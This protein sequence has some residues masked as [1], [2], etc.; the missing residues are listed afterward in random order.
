MSKIGLVIER[1]Y[2]TRVFKKSFLLVTILVPLLLMGFYAI[3]L[4]I[5]FKDKKAEQK[6]AVIDKSGFFKD[7]VKTGKNNDLEFEIL[8]NNNLEQAVKEYKVLGYNGLLYIPDGD[9]VAVKNYKLYLPSNLSFSTTMAIED[10]INKQVNDNRLIAQG[11]D[12]DTYNQSAPKVDLET[13]IDSGK[14]QNSQAS[15]GVAFAVSMVCGLL[16]YLMMIIYGTMVMRGVS[17]EKTN[18]I[19]EVLTSS[20]KPFDMMMGKIIGIGA[21]GLTQFAIWVVIA[22]ALQGVIGQF[23]GGS[24]SAA[25]AIN[26]GESQEILNEITAG[27][28]SLP[29]V[30]IGFAF[31][32]Y[33]L[34]GYLLYASL[35]AA[36]GS[37]VSDDQN[38]AQQLTFPIMMPIIIGFV[39]MMNALENPNGSLA[40]FGSL[41]PLTSPV[42][43]MGRITYDIPIWEIL[44]SIVLLILTFIFLTWLAAKIYRTGILLYGKKPSWKEMIKWAFK[45]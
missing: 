15:S 27:I 18:R 42:V 21:V 4:S 45:K 41:F 26:N 28:N 9:S 40:V 3:I 34:G 24:S 31:I 5:A 43:M 10:I 29:L 30:K 14:G 20:V 25:T 2:K 13:I 37:V 36:V 23:F 19:A 39:I 17:E 7:S 16:I 12:P 35:F 8:K 44:L 11:I 1:E 38:E 32:F 22:V 6:F 33:F